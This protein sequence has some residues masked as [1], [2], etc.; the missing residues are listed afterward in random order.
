MRIVFIVENFYPKIGGVETLFYNLALQ[1]SEQGHSI[2]VLTSGLKQDNIKEEK[3]NPNFFIH[4]LD[5]SNRYWFTF[6]GIFSMFNKAKGAD[7]IHTTSYNAGI[8]AS[9]IGLLL[10]KHV[11][12][13]FHEYWGKMWFDLAYFGKIKQWLHYTF[14]KILVKMPFTRFVAVS[15]YTKEALQSADIPESK[16]VR[17]YN[18]LQYEEFR[19]SGVIAKEKRIVFFGR[20]GIS[21]GVDLFLKSIKHVNHGD[22]RFE[23]ILSE[24]QSSYEEILK[25][26]IKEDGISDRVTFIPTLPFQEL[27]S[28]LQSSH[29]VIIPSYSEGFCFAA[30]ECVALGVPIISSGRGAL[31]EVVTG[32]YIEFDEFSEIGCAHAIQKAIQDDWSEKPIQHFRLKDTV[33]K[34]RDLYNEILENS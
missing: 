19:T 24:T 30:A 5:S 32:K 33:A 27:K 12:I 11:V 2:V 21:K 16:V 18:G 7:L 34:Y 17:I 26:I 20:L 14:E 6:F 29:A 22:F 9:L 13:T 3:I 8:P 23:C 10:R 28:Y 4:R 25:T 31:K 15:D 1:L